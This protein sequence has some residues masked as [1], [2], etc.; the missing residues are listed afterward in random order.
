M[1]DS[2]IAK[3]QMANLWG[4][5]IGELNQK[6]KDIEWGAELE[7]VPAKAQFKIGHVEYREDSE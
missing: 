7:S 5:A 2:I 1:S 6:I 3:R 4:R